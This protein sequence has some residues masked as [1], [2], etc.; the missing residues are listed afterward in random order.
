V[1]DINEPTTCTLLYVK[2]RMLRTIEVAD[3]IMMA[4]RIVH[5]RSIPSE[6]AVVEVTTIREGREFEDLDYP[7]EEEGI[8]KLKDAKG[9][10]VLWPH[11]D[12]ILKIGSS[13]IIS[14]Q[15]REDK[16]TPT[17]Q[18]TKCST[19][20]FT[21]PSQN[22]PQT[23][24][25]PKNSPPTQPLEHHS[26][27]CVAISKSPQTTPPLQNPPPTQPLEHHSPPCVAISMS[28]HTTPPL[29]NPP[30]TQPLEHDSLLRQ[31]PPL[32]T[33][34][35]NQPIEQALHHHSPPRVAVLKSP[36]HTTPPLQNPAPT[37]PLVHH[38]PLCQSPHTTT[39]QNPPTE[40]TLQ[41]HSPLHVYSP[42]STPHTIPP[43]RN[44]SIAHTLQ[45]HSPP[46]VSSP[47]SRPHTIPTPQNPPKAL[48]KQDATHTTCWG[49]VPTVLWAA[50][51]NP[52]NLDMARLP[53]TRCGPTTPD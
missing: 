30:P 46:C 5:G 43:P 11:K 4:T 33:T 37:Q 7:N 16:G 18:N 8:V 9:N 10:F 31:S 32:T 1:D 45:P 34:P 52:E 13:L 39:P 50:G 15:N 26:P 48:K 24:P 36:P 28:P 47:K 23:T 49:L 6:C 44:P 42:K 3:A 25:P 27:P 35:Q 40:Q 14:P 41:H 51:Y 2:D 53:H 17:S 38:S 22:P 19:A 29:Q 21:L 20:R 12:I